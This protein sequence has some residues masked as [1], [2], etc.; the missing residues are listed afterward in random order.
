ME[1]KSIFMVLALVAVGTLNAG[2]VKEGDL[3]K[4]VLDSFKSRFPEARHVRWEKEDD[5][6]YE[7]TFSHKSKQHS[8]NFSDKGTWLETE[9]EI[10]LSALPDG[11]RNLVSQK[12]SGYRIKE[13]A[14]LQSAQYGDCYELEIKKGSERLTILVD[15]KGVLLASFA[16]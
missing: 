10:K 11:V 6:S 5:A 9:E 15:K 14:S 7:A 16:E 2:R 13:T 12:Y 8:A 1:K 3:P 4:A